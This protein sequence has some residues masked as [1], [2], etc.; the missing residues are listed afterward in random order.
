MISDE[1]YSH[2][3][4]VGDFNY[5]NINWKNWSTNC[6]DHSLEAHFLQTVRE[7]FY[8]QHIDEATRARG[9]NDPSL[10]DLILTDEEMQ[11]SN[12]QYHDPL[13]RSLSQE[14]TFM[15]YERVHHIVECV[16]EIAV[17]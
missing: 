17:G 11:V 3:C 5:K 9:R 2:R 12:V 7:S 16:D 14:T 4:I 1:K 6:G 15:G 8:Y 13:G 10:L